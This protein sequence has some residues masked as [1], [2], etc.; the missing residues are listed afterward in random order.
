MSCA[1]LFGINS[2]PSRSAP[3]RWWLIGTFVCVSWSIPPT[4]AAA[5]CS[6]LL[7]PGWLDPGYY[8]N[9]L[10]HRVHD[11]RPPEIVE[12]VAAIAS[13]SQ[14]GPGEG[15]FHPGTSRY[16]WE[17]LAARHH[18]GKDGAISRQRFTGTVEFF[19]RLD[20]NHD[21]L[22]T[23]ADFDSTDRPPPVARR[24][25]SGTSRREPQSTSGGGPSPAILLKGLLSGEIGSMS[26][27]PRIGRQA[28]DFTLKTQDGRRTI[29][30]SDFRGKK[31]VVLVFGSFT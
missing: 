26:E 18:I 7:H 15:W 21:G 10:L 5:D 16:S 19:D 22:L 4:Q 12:M 17:W 13:G 2:S 8:A 3:H 6:P 29:R 23:Q 24:L 31:P 25:P 1:R 20:R 11:F 30:L 28:P 27:G 9:A 14:M